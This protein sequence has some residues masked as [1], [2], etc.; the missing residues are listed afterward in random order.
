MTAQNIKLQGFTPIVALMGKIKASGNEWPKVRL[1]IGDSPLVLTVA[2]NS[3]RFP[4]SI[5]LTDG[6]RYPAARFY[7]RITPLGDFQPSPEARKMDQGLKAELWAILSK[8]K[9]G[10][11]EE[12]FAEHGHATGNCCM[13]GRPLSNAESV[14]LG[15]GPICRGRAFG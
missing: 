9:A 8:M 12:V 11:A 14:E 4:G 6:G 10:K 2:G 15:I 5:N 1:S 7:G 3:A 13:C